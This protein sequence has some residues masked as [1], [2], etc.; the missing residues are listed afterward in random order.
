[1][2]RWKYGRL[3]IFVLQGAMTFYF[4]AKKPLKLLMLSLEKF[5]IPKS[6]TP[7]NT[8]RNGIAERVPFIS[9]VIIVL[10][11]QEL[12]IAIQYTR[13]TGD[14]IFSHL[15]QMTLREWSMQLVKNSQLQFYHDGLEH[16]RLGFTYGCIHSSRHH[17]CLVMSSK[18]ETNFYHTFDSQTVLAI[19]NSVKHFRGQLQAYNT[20]T[21]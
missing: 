16:K 13:G 4:K 12:L 7:A 17:E 9:V 3:N 21:R 20:V 14:D 15:T 8:G 18:I 1:M 19:Q 10:L 11:S 6:Q 5:R 2:S